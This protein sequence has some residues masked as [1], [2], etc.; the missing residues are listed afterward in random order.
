[1][2]EKKKSWWERVQKEF[3]IIFSKFSKLFDR[4]IY[5]KTSSIIVSLLASI[6]I[7]VSVSFDDLRYTFF[8]SE[9]ATLNVPGVSVEVRADTEKYEI[10]GGTSSSSAISC[11]IFTFD[12][13][14]SYMTMA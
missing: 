8:N 1:M 7:C 6:A 9:A 13:V 14:L 5:H 4:I 11:T 10:T 12:F 2:D 3:G